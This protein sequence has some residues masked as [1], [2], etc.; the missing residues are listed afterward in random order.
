MGKRR[1]K[2]LIADDLREMREALAALLDSYEVLTAADGEEAMRLA[3]AGKPALLLLDVNMPG[4]SGL[5]VLELSA[6]LSPRPMVVMITA[7]TDLET[8]IKAVSLGSYAYLTKPFDA[9][10]VRETVTA[11]LAEFDRR[12]P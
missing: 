9:G 2:I 7:E 3:A 6:G 4:L 5:Q 11:A 10:R 1:H 12:N 8:G